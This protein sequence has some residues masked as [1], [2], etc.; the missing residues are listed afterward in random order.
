MPGITI[1][2]GRVKALASNAGI[3]LTSWHMAGPA[4]AQGP[5]TILG[6][7]SKSE[8]MQKLDVGDNQEIME[9][10]MWTLGRLEWSFIQFQLEPHEYSGKRHKQQNYGGLLDRCPSTAMCPPLAWSVNHWNSSYLY[11][12]P[13]KQQWL[14]SIQ[15]AMA[16]KWEHNFRAY[17]AKHC[18]MRMWVLIR[19]PRPGDPH[20][21]GE[22]QETV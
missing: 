6:K 13:T 11:L 18:F 4:V 21:P 16:W 2:I 8:V 10:G 15:V 14:K 5:D 7:N 17:A 12:L 19:P 20:H 3:R 1:H 22:L 9:H